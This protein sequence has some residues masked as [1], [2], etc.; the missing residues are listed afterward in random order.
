MPRGLPIVLFGLAIVSGVAAPASAQIYSYR[1][2]SGSLV[3]SDAAPS[4]PS[5]SVRTFEAVNTSERVRVTRPVSKAYREQFDELIVHY[6]EAQG[7]RPDLVRAVVQVESGYNPRA[8]SPKGAMGLMQLMPDTA[9]ALGV[10][11]PFDPEENVRGGVAY[12]RHLLDRF[13]GNEELALAAY[14]AGPAAVGR[15]GN[16]IPPYR[17]TRDYVRK[18][19][20][21]TTVSAAAAKPKLVI[22]K[23]VELVEG[24]PVTRY[25]D[26]PPATGSYERVPG[27]R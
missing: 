14:N 9:A 12:L 3:L 21:R 17:E 25:S 26:S 6:A 22:Y 2:A 4:D 10:K 27:G 19:R 1:D 24:K 7:I 23:W 8:L 13:N 5:L 15:Y 11:R 18:V 20:T 16:R